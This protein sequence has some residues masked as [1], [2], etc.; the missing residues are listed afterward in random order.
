MSV[1]STG[2]A[3]AVTVDVSLAVFGIVFFDAQAGEWLLL[4]D[5][6]MTWLMHRLVKLLLILDRFL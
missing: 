1:M 5:R 4:L 2:H 6:L 3:T